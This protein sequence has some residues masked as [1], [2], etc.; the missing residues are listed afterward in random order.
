MG[1]ITRDVKIVDLLSYTPE[2]Y[3][4]PECN[5]KI[6]R[7][8]IQDGARY[9]VLSYDTNGIHCSEPQCEENHNHKSLKESL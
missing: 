3:Q 5:V 1:I 6:E 4:C 8:I 7:H 9:H 2:Y